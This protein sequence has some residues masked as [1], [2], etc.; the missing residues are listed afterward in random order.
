MNTEQEN[1]YKLQLAHDLII[2]LVN[3][4]TNGFT[5]DRKT[6]R[7]NMVLDAWRKEVDIKIRELNE[8]YLKQTSKTE[9]MG[10]DEIK[11]LTDIHQIEA[12]DIRKAFKTEVGHNVMNSFKIET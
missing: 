12:I 9:S 1:F 5:H 7:T 11:I 2:F 8:T 3:L 10:E 4:Q 6:E